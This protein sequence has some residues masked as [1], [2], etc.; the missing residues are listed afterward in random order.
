MD[1]R[2][3]SALDS[4]ISRVSRLFLA[5]ES[6]GGWKTHSIIHS[7][8]LKRAGGRSDRSFLMECAC[9]L[10]KTDIWTDEWAN[11]GHDDRQISNRTDKRKNREG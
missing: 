4:D 10:I 9:I 3:E 6:L 7:F 5:L 1:F 11:E 8:L 2:F